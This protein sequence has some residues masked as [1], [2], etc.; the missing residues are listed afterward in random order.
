[1]TPPSLEAPNSGLLQLVRGT[2]SR[3]T[4]TSMLRRSLR[5]PGTR[6]GI[7][8]CALLVL[9]AVIG[10][11]LAPD[12][13]TAIVGLPLQT[14]TVSH[15]FG[16]DFLGRDVLS[17]F[18]NGGR[19]LILLAL[20]ATVFG[21]AVGVA[22]GITAGYTR[23]WIDSVLMRCS[24]VV[25]SFPALIL[26]LV[27]LATLGPKLWLVVAGVALTHVPR[28]ARLVR[29]AALEVVG[30]EYVSAAEARGE[31]VRAILFREILPNIWTPILIDFGVR[32]A[33]SVIIIS[34]LSF[35]GFGLQPPASD[36]GLMINENRSALTIQPY[37]VLFPLLAIAALA[38]GVN[39]IADGIV[40]AAMSGS[41]APRK[42]GGLARL[43]RR[44]A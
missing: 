28:V 7:G 24:D 20:L 23:N 1:V 34:S 12:S 6:I 5:F 27:L 9:L 38:I 35:L 19:S 13:P 26:A 40:R 44:E 11:A 41:S 43:I 25:M 18:L 37:A 30:Q 42:G 15:P 21:S 8:I 3:G 32:L 29:G 33:G 4:S 14:P 16:L 17:R 22:V 36:W 10:P 2:V 31:P 39:L